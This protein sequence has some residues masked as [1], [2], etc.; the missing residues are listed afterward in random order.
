[1]ET[2]FAQ[3]EALIMSMVAHVESNA[4]AIGKQKNK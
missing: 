1:M 3:L 4:F 2:K